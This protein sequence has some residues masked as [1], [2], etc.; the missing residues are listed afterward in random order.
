MWKVSVTGGEEIEIQERMRVV[1]GGE[2]TVFPAWHGNALRSR[3]P[4]PWSRTVAS[5][6]VDQVQQADF[7][8][9]DRADLDDQRRRTVGR[10]RIRLRAQAVV[11]V[12]GWSVWAAPS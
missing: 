12:V 11:D 6:L 9:L 3:W 1:T 5:A 8:D 7:G 2:D 4:G 10:R